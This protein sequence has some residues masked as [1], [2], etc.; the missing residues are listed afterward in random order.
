M[1]E[2]SITPASSDW[3]WP[4]CFLATGQCPRPSHWGCLSPSLL[5]PDQASV[6]GCQGYGRLNADTIMDH[7]GSKPLE[8]AITQALQGPA[9]LLD[10]FLLDPEFRSL[11]RHFVLFRIWTCPPAPGLP[12]GVLST[13]VPGV[14]HH[15]LNLLWNNLPFLGSA[16]QPSTSYDLALRQP[17]PPA[18]TQTHSPVQPRHIPGP[19]SEWLPCKGGL[20][21]GPG[22]R[23]GPPY[24]PLPRRFRLLRI[25]G[26]HHDPIDEEAKTWERT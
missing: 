13:F 4:A 26:R 5:A 25:G 6:A 24:A 9:S 19:P 11:G 2:S 15:D 18:H 12:I 16:L 23:G 7:A 17:V 1:S 22:P 3:H 8:P 14:V 21:A 20:H 10:Q